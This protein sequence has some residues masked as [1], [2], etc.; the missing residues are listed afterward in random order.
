MEKYKVYKTINDIPTEGKS[1]IEDL[2]Q[3][4]AISTI[5]N[6]FSIND[7]VYQILIILAKLGII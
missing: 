4:G 7:C 5:N 6:E 2:I 3:K 1:L